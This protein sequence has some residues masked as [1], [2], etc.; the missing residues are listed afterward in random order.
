[1]RVTADKNTLFDL[2]TWHG[3]GS[4]SGLV[5]VSVAEDDAPAVIE[6]ASKDGGWRCSTVTTTESKQGQAAFSVL[7]VLAQKRLGRRADHMTLELQDSAV[8]SS[9]GRSNASSP[10]VTDIPEFWRP[11]ENEDGQDPFTVVAEVDATSLGWLLRVGDSMRSGDPTLPTRAATLIIKDGSVSI[12]STDTYKMGFGQ[13]ESLVKDS[14]GTYYIAPSDFIAPLSIMSDADTVELVESNGHIGLRG[15]GSIML[16]PA[17]ASGP[18]HMESFLDGA[19]ETLQASTPLILPVSDFSDALGGVG[20]GDNGSTLI[21]V[22]ADHIVV[23]NSHSPSRIEGC[24]EAEVEAEVPEG[25][26]GSTFKFNAANA[27]A[28]I[29]QFRTSNLAMTRNKRMVILAE[30]AGDSG[31]EV[32][33]VANISL[34]Q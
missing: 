26:N 10:A 17:M 25:A 12:H 9:V 24:T 31:E 33:F 21:E 28:A 29:K 16:R 23:S 3:K 11:Q 7:R 1:M 34:V 20:L 8:T 14:E 30:P 13:I 18:P 27:S 4:T 15:A 6:S 2:L 19:H 22:R 32:P 5:R